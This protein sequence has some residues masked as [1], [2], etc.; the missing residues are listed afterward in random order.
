[1]NLKNLKDEATRIKIVGPELLNRNIFLSA[2]AGSG[3][4][5]SLV[6][7]VMALIRNGVAVSSI[8]AITFTREAAK[9]FYGRMT[10]ELE[11][12][13]A[14]TLDPQER[15]RYEMAFE[16]IDNAFFGTIDS[17]CRKLLLEHP[18]EA[19]ITSQ[20]NPLEK[21]GDKR[22]IVDKGIECL[23]RE[24]TPA[25]VYQHYQELWKWDFYGEEFAQIL[26]YVLEEDIFD[27]ELG[28]EPEENRD[29]QV[30]LHLEDVQDIGLELKKE[31]EKRI[32]FGNSIEQSRG[33][34]TKGSIAAYEEAIRFIGKEHPVNS[35][36]FLE[37]M[38]KA[39]TYRVTKGKAKIPELLIERARQLLEHSI[40]EAIKSEYREIRYY[41]AL[42][43]ANEMRNSL[44][45]LSEG[46]GFISYSRSLKR[47][48][49]ML[50]RDKD[51]GGELLSYLREKYRYYLIDEL[52]D[53]NQLQSQ[54]FDLL[55]GDHP[56]ALFIVGDEKQAIYRFRGG[57]VDNFRRLEKSMVM[58]AGAA[59]LQLT[60][61]F[62]SSEPLRL[63]FNEK[64]KEEAFF[65]DD[66]PPIEAAEKQECYKKFKDKVIDGVYTFPVIQTKKGTTRG[67]TIPT[68]EHQLVV[69]IIEKI[70]G[71][72]I[73]NYN[74]KTKTMGT[75]TLG[76]GDILVL[77]Y[78]KKKLK[79]YMSIFKM[80]NI[81][82]SVVGSSNLQS[83]KSLAMM[84]RVLDHLADPKNT[85]KEGVCLLGEPFSISE[86]ELYGY[87]QGRA[88]PAVQ[89]VKDFLEQL[90]LEL[91][92]KTPS[93]IYAHI[94]DRMKL[95][96]MSAV[97]N[98][99]EASD[100]LH[101]GLEL[102][103]EGEAYGRIR[104]LK[105]LGE[106][107]RGDLL[108]GGYEYELSLSGK[109]KGVRLMNL[110]KA[111]GLE[112]RVVILA[113][114]G[115]FPSGNGPEKQYDFDNHSVK[116]FRVPKGGLRSN[117]IYTDKFPKELEEEKLKLE[118]EIRRLKYVAATRAE[119]VL[120][121]PTLYKNVGDS[122]LDPL[123][124]VA[125]DMTEGKW[126]SL[127][128]EDLE[129][130]L[131]K[132]TDYLIAQPMEML[133]E[134][135]KL[136]DLADINI[137][138]KSGTEIIKEFEMPY[139]YKEGSYETINPSKVQLKGAVLE[140]VIMEDQGE[141]I[142]NL[143][144]EACDS[145]S[146]WEKALAKW[147]R[148]GSIVGTL[149]HALMEALVLRLPELLDQEECGILLENLLKLYEIPEA[150]K[151]FFRTT[152]RE[153]YNRMIA[154]GYTQDWAEIPL[155][156]PQDLLKELASAEEIYTEL[157]FSIYGEK[158][159]PLMKGLLEGLNI[160]EDKDGYLNGI[161]DLVYK[162][163]GEYFILDYKTNFSSKDLHQHYE[164][165]IYLYKKILKESF[166]LEYE[167]K[168]YLYH[169]PARDESSLPKRV[170]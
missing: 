66:F 87:K 69:E 113:D 127:L 108:T 100:T 34:A 136:W 121:I 126:H 158:K 74:H 168:A 88:I 144:G 112:S 65:G 138:E 117:Y 73:S 92:E 51:R 59:V 96:Y 116:I 3:K 167:P 132:K 165:Q 135:E 5:S 63:W 162:K 68:N 42:T 77:A 94:M 19:K 72:P 82:Y 71:K 32:I 101:Y 91:E 120:I 13:I 49:E 54:L 134:Q 150:D 84:D 79:E 152:L 97:Y 147:Q 148:E 104:N 28:E 133:E 76:Y 26:L 21:P 125:G 16:E 119:N 12:M 44:L 139:L 50:Q 159:D 129:N 164:A 61:N 81:P 137:T 40:S 41:K 78:S 43:W 153:V 64:F 8:V 38:V 123:V 35:L 9:M 114:A 6:N 37:K 157:P 143:D 115:P 11:L 111:K 22:A 142:N 85:Y 146:E 141:I 130:I 39:F 56:G 90:A 103:R 160:H 161:M 106:F 67:P 70:L 30:L 7:R 52:Q 48:V 31:Y 2:G 107:I 47:L 18:A 98:I 57:D 110:H 131:E 24:K 62:R 170:D 89:T 17:F 99:E 155:R 75:H 163:A 166:S 122:R 156:C 14:G 93:A 20:L 53:T 102:V 83:S 128:T 10:S 33:L 45:L 95:I 149:V 86:K 145:E 4:T 124:A 60:C 151:E 109:T 154:G 1:M 29:P 140:D 58:E 36:V 23:L 15:G 27:L 25:E 80:N 105:D 169:I 46:Q 55:A 118:E